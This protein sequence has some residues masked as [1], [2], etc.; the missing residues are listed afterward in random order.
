MSKT[1]RH[2]EY[3]RRRHASR[4][5]PDPFENVM[6]TP[7][8]IKAHAL[9]YKNKAWQQYSEEELQWWVHLL[10]KRANHR[11]NEEKKAKD[12]YDAGN[13]QAMLDEMRRADNE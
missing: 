12:L 6:Q 3:T 8:Q 2:A 11:D 5:N 4:L 10:T 13:Y 9:D 7:E 1:E